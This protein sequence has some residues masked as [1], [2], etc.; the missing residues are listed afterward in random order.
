MAKLTSSSQRRAILLYLAFV[1]V[2][3][4][5]T[6][7][8]HVLLEI[9][10]FVE[11]KDDPQYAS[12]WA[13]WP[14]Y[15]AWY[16]TNPWSLVIVL[17]LFIACGFCWLCVAYILIYP[18]V[19]FV[20]HRLQK[21]CPFKIRRRTWC[22]C[23]CSCKSLEKILRGI[24]DSHCKWEPQ[25]PDSLD[26]RTRRYVTSILQGC[27]E[28]FNEENMYFWLVGSSAEGLGKPYTVELENGY[29]DPC[30]KFL[31]R[32]SSAVVRVLRLTLACEPALTS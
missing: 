1:C 23:N 4:P 16:Q 21:Y 11:L 15:V 3:L 31:L 2:V 29:A 28:R 32:L 6:Y 30:C 25:R 7:K 10:A 19:Y 17:L 5:A 8:L 18:V 12:F 26:P 22:F 24:H 9:V 14:L 20:W 27:K 13:R